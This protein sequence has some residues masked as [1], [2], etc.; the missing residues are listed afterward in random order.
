MLLEQLEVAT[1]R[2]IEEQIQELYEVGTE[3]QRSQLGQSIFSG[4]NFAHQRELITDEARMELSWAL[5][6]AIFG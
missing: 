1:M 5:H 4:I 3:K 2:Q 6:N